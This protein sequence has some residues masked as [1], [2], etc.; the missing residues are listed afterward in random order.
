M[1]RRL[2]RWNGKQVWADSPPGL[3]LHELVQWLE[4]VANDAASQRQTPKVEYAL[5]LL[6]CYEESAVEPLINLLPQTKNHWMYWHI[7]WAL[8][9]TGDKRALEPLWEIYK[10]AEDLSSQIE[11]IYSLS[12]LKD[13][14]LFEIALSVFNEESI[15]LKK[16]AVRAF[17]NS[18]DQRAVEILLP[19]LETSN[20]DMRREVIIALGK[21]KDQRALQP[22]ITNIP[23]ASLYEKRII[24]EALG[25]IGGAEAISALQMIINADD[26]PSLTSSQ[27][28]RLRCHAVQAI[29]EISDPAALP[30]LEAALQHRKWGVRRHARRALA[31]HLAREG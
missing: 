24:V 5:R 10:N 9:E 16:Y 21:L 15:N 26:I 11:A 19:L 7:I 31:K 2:W 22:L 18:G 25:R 14:R 8:G 13:K 6:I 12:L 29:G 3:W 17:G 30:A 27:Y 20:E 4:S 28:D 23:D 1:N